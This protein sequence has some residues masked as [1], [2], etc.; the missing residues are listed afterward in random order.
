MA[1]EDSSTPRPVRI[2]HTAD[3]QIGMPFHWVS[4]DAGAKLRE[5]RLEVLTRIGDLARAEQVDVVVVAGDFFDAN[6]IDDRTVAAACARVRDTGVPFVVIPGNH[7]F[8][9]GPD[10]VYRRRQFLVSQPPNLVVA[11]EREPIVLSGGRIVVLPAP[12]TKRHSV[13]DTTAHITASL[14]ADVA[15]DAVR[16]GLAHGDVAGF[17]RDDDGHARNFIAPDRATT[18]RLDYLALGDWHGLKRIDERTWYSGAPEPTGF[19]DND[20]GHVL[21]VTIANAGAVP[22]VEPRAIAATVLRR[23]ARELFTPE[24]VARL[25]SELGSLPRAR[26]TVLDLC[27]TGLLGVPDCT[28]IEEILLRT[29]GNLLHLRAD[30]EGLAES[31]SADELSDVVPEGFARVVAVDLLKR[32]RAGNDEG[33]RASLALRI[34]RHT[35]SQMGE[36]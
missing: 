17:N 11:T 19:K 23:L 9:A 28:R 1:H 35:A 22:Q 29:Q 26:E 31:V 20:P 24:D 3:L 32:A 7:D 14:G 12:L 5:A 21:L 27:L 6:T 10:C 2:L 13:E 36:V 16:I 34:L 25:E 33:R 18:G 8:C 4:G 30:R 15:P